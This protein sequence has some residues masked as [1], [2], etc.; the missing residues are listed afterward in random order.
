MFGIIKKIKESPKGNVSIIAMVAGMVIIVGTASMMG[1]MVKDINFAE[2]DEAKL[3]A[4]NLAEA[5]LSDFYNKIDGYYSGEIE[6]L[7]ASPYSIDIV[8]DS[9]TQGNATVEYIPLYDDDNEIIGY[10]ITSTGADNTGITRSINMNLIMQSESFEFDIFDYIYSQGSVMVTGNMD[11]ILNGTFFVNDDIKNVGNTNLYLGPTIVSGDLDIMGSSTRVGFPIYVNGNMTASG[12]CT[13][14]SDEIDPLLVVMQ[15]LEVTGD[16]IVGSSEN[17]VELYVGGDFSQSGNGVIYFNWSTET[18]TFDF[19]EFDVS[20]YVTE[21]ID[22]MG[23]TSLVIDHDLVIEKDD[24]FN[25]TDG[26]NTLYF[27]E[28]NSEYLLEI[29]GSVM[30]N[31]NITIGED[32]KWDRQYGI[33]YSGKG[34]LISTGDVDIH[35]R[36]RPV[37]REEYPDYTNFPSVDLMMLASAQNMNLSLREAEYIADSNCSLAD[38]YMVGIAGGSITFVKENTTIYGTLIGGNLDFGSG[39]GYTTVCYAYDLSESIPPSVPPGT[40]GGGVYSF[41]EG[42]WQEVNPEQSY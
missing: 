26:T 18:Y 12:D 21:I 39:N 24:Y 29:N 20:D 9:L 25:L 13:L 14:L 34:I 27:H 17:P 30:V 35:C 36:M 1:Y 3:R 15:D 33:K 8:V 38:L 41:E 6:S 32:L 2:L 37:I 16:A 42:I 40:S 22:G 10:F 4:I 23:T 5:G 31:G 28:E 19:P 11:V 7:P